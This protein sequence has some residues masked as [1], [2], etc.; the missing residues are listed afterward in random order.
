MRTII[1]LKQ[2]WNIVIDLTLDS[3]VCARKT[4]KKMVNKYPNTSFCC[5]SLRS[6]LTTIPKTA[7]LTQ[8]FFHSF[9]LFSPD[10]L[11]FSHIL[12]ISL[13][14]LIL[15]CYHLNQRIGSMCQELFLKSNLIF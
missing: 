14:Y 9:K 2:T 12:Y 13:F 6:S 4:I 10:I 3:S 7:T 1:Q 11:S 8:Q 5:F 15:I